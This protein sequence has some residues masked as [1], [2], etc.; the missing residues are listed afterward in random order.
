MWGRQLNF[1]RRGERKLLEVTIL[2][3]LESHVLQIDLIP[4]PVKL[5]YAKSIVS[6]APCKSNPVR[7]MANVG[8]A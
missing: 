8:T 4:I 7:P 6:R 3:S 1:M 5:V 2:I